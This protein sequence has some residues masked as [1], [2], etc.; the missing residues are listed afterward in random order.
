VTLAGGHETVFGDL[1]IRHKL[2][3]LITVTAAIAVILAASALLVF[4]SVDLRRVAVSEISTLAEMIGS[5]TSAAVTFQDPRA[6]E[7]ILSALRADKRVLAA[8]VFTKGGS[9]F[10]RYVQA[11]TPA[12][13][14]RMGIRQPGYYFENSTLIFVRPILLDGEIIGTILLQNDM[15][16]DYA[17]MRRSVGLMVLMIVLSFA[18]ALLFTM[19]VQRGISEPLLRLAAT[20]RQV[21]SAKNYA[22]RAEAHTND[23]IGVLI[24]AFN[25]MLAQN[26]GSRP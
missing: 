1:S 7:E 26:P 17:H 25:E 14:G 8:L 3:L 24:G 16:I 22:V 4:K 12:A 21:S 13:R 9:T 11:G 15:R 2:G 23:E 19:R 20:A 6:G 5:N 10:A 18:L